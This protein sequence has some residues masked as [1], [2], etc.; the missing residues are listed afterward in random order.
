MSIYHKKPISFVS[1][2]T[3][4]IKNLAVSLPFYTET[5]GFHLIYADNEQAILGTKH[6]IPLLTL[7][8]L[9]NAKPKTMQ[10]AGLYHF[11]ILLPTRKD[12]GQILLH[13][14]KNKITL[15][16]ASNHGISEAIYL[17]DPDGN[18][19]EFAAD[20]DPASWPPFENPIEWFSVN[21]PMDV[22]AV[23]KESGHEPF[24]GLPDDAIFGH[25]HLHVSELLQTKEFY[26]KGLGMD[27]VMEFA[28][29]AIFFSYGHYHHHIATNVWNGK[30]VKPKPDNVPGLH[31]FDLRLS[32][33]A[34]LRETVE[35]LRTL[36]Y[37]VTEKENAQWTTDPSGNQI[38]L[39][40]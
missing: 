2:A 36:G 33:E 28:D 14:I 12:L 19:I 29:S 5:L 18:G 6:G 20:T 22:E 24:D 25:I 40:V 32:D 23:I 8:Q 26:T 31:H 10:T 21:G 38:R 30:G 9:T 3:I 17:A 35:R 15:Q 1:H 11:A 27:V 16:G 13:F 37:P 4:G 7:N 34:V 39:L